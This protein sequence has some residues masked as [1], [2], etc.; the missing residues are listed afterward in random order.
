M[1]TGPCKIPRLEQLRISLP[2]ELMTILQLLDQTSPVGRADTEKRLAYIKQVFDVCGGV[3]PYPPPVGIG[4][5]QWG[6]YLDRLVRDH[7][8]EHLCPECGHLL[9]V[10]TYQRGEIV[11]L[12]DGCSYRLRK[13]GNDGLGDCIDSAGS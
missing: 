9:D 4:R 7:G 8:D 10:P 3:M 5:M 6:D 1:R 11:C 12:R 13:E 2:G